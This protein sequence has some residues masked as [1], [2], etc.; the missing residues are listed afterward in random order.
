MSKFEMI[1][2]IP[3]ETLPELPDEKKEGLERHETEQEKER[4]RTRVGSA[5]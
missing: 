2:Q 4:I 5:Y 1:K 3:E